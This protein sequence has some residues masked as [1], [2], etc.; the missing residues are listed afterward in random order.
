MGRRLRR[1]VGIA[2]LI[3]FML[4]Y[5]VA[6]AEIGAAYFVEAA[7]LVELAYYIVAGVAWTVPVAGIIAWMLRGP[8]ADRA[9]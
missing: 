1:V 8:K 7:T 3:L 9:R 6:A 2:A 4:A 5:V